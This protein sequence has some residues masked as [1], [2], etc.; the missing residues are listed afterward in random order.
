[1]LGDAV[2]DVQARNIEP[3]E[4]GLVS[5]ADLKVYLHGSGSPG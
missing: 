2:V 1:M 3:T 4:M 5:I